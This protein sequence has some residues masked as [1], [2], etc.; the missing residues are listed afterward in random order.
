MDENNQMKVQRIQAFKN[1][2]L[3]EHMVSNFPPS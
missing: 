3:I 1:E 2:I